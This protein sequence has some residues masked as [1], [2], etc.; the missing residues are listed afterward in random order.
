MKDFGTLHVDAARVEPAPD[1]SSVNVLLRLEGASMTQ[2]TLAAG[3]T[4]RA[5]VHRTVEE[6]WLFLSGTGE[7]WRRQG[8]RE[9]VTFIRP[10]TCVSIPLGT[11][12]QLR[13]ANDAPLVAVAAT[14]PP[15][16]GGGEATPVSGRWPS[17][18]ASSRED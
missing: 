9:E 2:F 4:S 18:A 16:P 11:A 5:V 1:G 8:A 3:T 15:W 14:M 13:A 12:F 10:G 6:L 17:T 7:L